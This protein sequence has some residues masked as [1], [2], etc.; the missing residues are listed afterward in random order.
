M[1]MIEHGRSAGFAFESLSP[2][3]ITGHF[4]REYLDGDDSIQA[5]VARLIDFAHSPGTDQ[6]DDFVSTEANTGRKRHGEF[7]K[8]A[9][10]Y[11]ARH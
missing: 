8:A 4:L 5:G 6:P 3:E 2:I 11:R 1:G 9:W 10:N 7:P